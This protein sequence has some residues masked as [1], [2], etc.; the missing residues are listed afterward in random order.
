MLNIKSTKPNSQ[1]GAVRPSSPI[2][3][4]FSSP[5]SVFIKNKTNYE[6]QENE[7]ARNRAQNRA[8]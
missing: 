2:V 8:S 6:R 3:D 5:S 1:P 7:Q 4:L